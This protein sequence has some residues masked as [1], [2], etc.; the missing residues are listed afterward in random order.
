MQKETREM[1]RLEVQFTLDKTSNIIMTLTSM[2]HNRSYDAIK[3]NRRAES[4]IRV[5]HYFHIILTYISPITYI[6]LTLIMM[7][8]IAI[9]F[10]KAI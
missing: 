2:I 10:C 4:S 9:T 1:A 7:S 5:I 3:S 8:Y 6:Y